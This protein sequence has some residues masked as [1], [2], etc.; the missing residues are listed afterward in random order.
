MRLRLRLTLNLRQR[1]QPR[2]QQR[3]QQRPQQ[4]QQQPMQNNWN[5]QDIEAI[6]TMMK[7]STDNTSTKWMT[8]QRHKQKPHM[9][10]SGRRDKT[11]TPQ[12]QHKTN[13]KDMRQRL[14][15]LAWPVP[16]ANALTSHPATGGP[17]CVPPRHLLC[18]ISFPLACQPNYLPNYR[19]P[20]SLHCQP[21]WCVRPMR[22]TWRIARWLHVDYMTII[23]ELH[24]DY[25]WG[26]LEGCMKIARDYMRITRGLH[27]D[28]I[29]ITSGLNQNYM[30][31]ARGLHD[32]YM[33]R[34]WREH[35]E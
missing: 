32:N 22:V 16:A 35:G 2:P 24:K 1:P 26:W 25:T 8:H 17:N 23:C 30:K 4:R 19:H 11:Q 3:L 18:R 31:T 14:C 21:T 34:T 9:S 7:T 6:N 27:E 29:R 15:L 5:A 28:Y 12:G 13:G 10:T 33:K 20:P